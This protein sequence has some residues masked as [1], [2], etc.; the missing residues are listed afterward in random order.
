MEDVIVSAPVRAS[1]SAW[2][3]SHRRLRRNCRWL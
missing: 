3:L 1:G 2:S